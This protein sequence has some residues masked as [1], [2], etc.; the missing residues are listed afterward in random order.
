M[1]NLDKFVCILI[2]C[3]ELSLHDLKIVEMAQKCGKAKNIIFVRS[4][5]DEFMRNKW[6]YDQ[7]LDYPPTGENLESYN[8][9]QERAAKDI[10]ERNFYQYKFN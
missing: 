1:M 5:M 10:E 7:G 3:G 4:K 8:A 9:F 2:F 6:R